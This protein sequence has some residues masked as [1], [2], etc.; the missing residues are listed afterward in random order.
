M[1]G[2]ELLGGRVTTLKRVLKGL[3]G[4]VGVDSESSPQSSPPI[5]FLWSVIHRVHSF[6]ASL[7]G[8]KTVHLCITPLTIFLLQFIYW[9]FFTELP[10]KHNK[11]IGNDFCR[12]MCLI[13]FV[14]PLG[15]FKF[16]RKIDPCAFL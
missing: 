13:I 12:C 8:K 7:A 16:P 14:F 3:A 15:S 11:F 1:G 6:F 9:V 10:I 5:S 2:Q 4:R